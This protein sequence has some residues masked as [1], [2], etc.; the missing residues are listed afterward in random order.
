MQGSLKDMSVADI[1]QHNCQDRKTAY[2]EIHNNGDTARVY[3]FDGAVVHAALGP[4]TGEE[5]IYKILSWDEGDFSL[6]MGIEAPVVTIKRA[7]SGLLLEGAK[8]LDEES[9]KEEEDLFGEA[10]SVDQKTQQTQGLLK[11][12]LAQNPE[13][14]GIAITGIDGFIRHSILPDGYDKSL[15]GAVSA[16]TL[17]FGRRSINSLC[18]DQF[19]QAVILGDSSA[20]VISAINKYSLLI[21]VLAE[22]PTDLTLLTHLFTD[23]GQTLAKLI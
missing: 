1:I 12:F 10:Q 9:Q 15:T 13:M 22:K 5:V 14:K 19:Y 8:R 17:N 16:A 4:T 7:W 3:F 11:N 6:E 2:V 21:G 23:L 20:I 18:H